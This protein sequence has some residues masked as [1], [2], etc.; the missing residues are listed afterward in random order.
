M[1]NIQQRVIEIPFK[2]D[3]EGF[4]YPIC[5]SQGM[6]GIVLKEE[7]C[8]KYNCQHYRKIRIK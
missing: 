1:I 5:T 4:Y 2:L 7:D 6:Q 3:K 8:I